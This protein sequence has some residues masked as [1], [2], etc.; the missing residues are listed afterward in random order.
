ML[1]VGQIIKHLSERNPQLHPARLTLFN[2]LQ[3]LHN[4][5]ELF[6][7][8]ILDNFVAATLDYTHWQQN[9]S[10]LGQEMRSLLQYFSQELTHDPEFQT[11]RMPESYQVFEVQSKLDFEDSLKAYLHSIYRGGEK[12]RLFF[13]GD[14][15]AVAVVLQSDGRI[16][17]RHFDR[18]FTI[19]HGQLEPLKKDLCLQYNERLEL[20]PSALQMIEV[21]PYITAYVRDGKGLLLRGYVFQRF[22]E[23]KNA[24]LEAYP[25]LFYA[26]KRTEQ[27]FVSRQTDAFYSSVMTSLERIIT[28]I[29]TGDPGTIQEAADV[30]AKAQNALEFVYTGDKLL[31]LQVKDLQNTLSQFAITSQ[32]RPLTNQGITRQIGARLI[33]DVARKEEKPWP[34]KISSD[35]TS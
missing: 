13:E 31:S 19:R 17:A 7:A 22:M 16:S 9:A 27:F 14:R 32:A 23:L 34:I 20:E 11:L 24:D 25:K 12:F 33:L 1:K 2:Y 18:K 8:G 15:R 35:L 3:F 6:T 4:P 5:N 30:L 28:L 26:L 10:T 21:A 29:K